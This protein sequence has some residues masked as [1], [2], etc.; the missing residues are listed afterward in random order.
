MQ[1][2]MLQTIDRR[3]RTSDGDT[4]CALCGNTLPKG[5]VYTQETNVSTGTMIERDICANCQGSDPHNEFVN[6]VIVIGVSLAFV[7]IL[8]LALVG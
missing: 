8:A 1:E 6:I 2:T 5:E 7:G 3:A 4:V